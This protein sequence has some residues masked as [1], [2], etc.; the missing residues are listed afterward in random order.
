MTGMRRLT[1]RDVDARKLR[2]LIAER[3]L[4]NAEVADRAG[5]AERTVRRATHGGFVR[6]T[7]ARALADSLGSGIDTFSTPAEVEHPYRA[8]SCAG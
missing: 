4:S 7:T 5:I 8:H 1:G 3:G 2:A 6:L